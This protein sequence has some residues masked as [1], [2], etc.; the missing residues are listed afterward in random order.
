MGVYSQ[1]IAV[2]ELPML[3]PSLN[4]VVTIE[5]KEENLDLE[6]DL[7][8]DFNGVE[9]TLPI[10][11]RGNLPSKAPDDHVGARMLVSVACSPMQITHEGAVTVSIDDGGG[12]KVVGKLGITLERPAS[13]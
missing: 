13:A 10:N 7:K 9:Q 2:T 8:I 12:Y 6:G 11:F 5:V 1:G 4:A 3:L